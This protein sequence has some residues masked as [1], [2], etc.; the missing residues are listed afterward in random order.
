MKFQHRIKCLMKPKI[1]N[2]NV[3][4]EGYPYFLL[5]FMLQKYN[6]FCKTS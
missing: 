5:I 6:D 3:V 2:L 1:K 4:D